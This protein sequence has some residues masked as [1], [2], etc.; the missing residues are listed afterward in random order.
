MAS[1]S[2][3]DGASCLLWFD[4]WMGQPMRLTCP[5]LFS[6]VKKPFLSLKCAASSSNI[7]N[8][9]HLPLSTEVFAQFQ[10]LE[11]T[12]QSLQ[13]SDGADTW[14]Y[15]WGSSTFTSKKAYCQLWG[16]SQ[17]HPIFKWIWKSSCQHNHKVFFWLLVHDRLST[18]NILRRMHMHLPS[19]FCMLCS[20]SHEETVQHLFLDCDMAKACW[21][22]LGLT[23]DTS[24]EPLQIF[25]SLR[26]QL[27]VSFFMEIIIIMS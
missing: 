27:N 25:E 5:E 3:V 24:L 22:T 10:L 8:L 4:C 11:N 21:A 18:R 20:Q 9:F 26:L 13:L 17:S 2:V 23:I 16:R 15:I 1:V 19:Y 12:L 14:N 6:F 7:T